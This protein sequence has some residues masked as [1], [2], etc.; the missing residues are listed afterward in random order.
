MVAFGF[1]EWRLHYHQQGRG[2]GTLGACSPPWAAPPLS[3][4][5]RRWRPLSHTLSHL[6]SY[7]LWLA[8]SS[9]CQLI[10][11]HEYGAQEKPYSRSSPPPSPP[12][13][14]AAGVPE[15]PL[16]PLPNW[17]KGRRSSSDRTCDRSRMRSPFVAL[18]F[19]TLRS[20]VYT[21]H[22]PRLFAGTLSRF[23]SSRVSPSETVTSNLLDMI[24]GMLQT[25]GN[26]LFSMQRTHQWYQSR[27]YAQMLCTVRTH[28]DVGVDDH[29]IAYFR[30]FWIMVAQWDEA[31]RT[32]FTCPRT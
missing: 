18:I 9:P 16:L 32:N 12:C 19:A 17:S 5:Q 14:S 8:S 22:H 4:I 20:G 21:L 29:V 13:R 6:L 15:D 10:Q 25:V 27:V 23:L 1:C 30:V 3:Y 11:F 2:G 7:A 26:F 24:L 28:V 31:A